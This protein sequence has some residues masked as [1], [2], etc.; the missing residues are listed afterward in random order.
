LGSFYLKDIATIRNNDWK[1]LEQY[2]SIP[3]PKKTIDYLKVELNNK[4]LIPQNFEFQVFDGSNIETE[5]GS[6]NSVLCGIGTRN[7]C[8][9]NSK[10]GSINS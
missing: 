5:N 3:S 10:N 9:F 4:C 7:V 2:F 1:N 6:I 8:S